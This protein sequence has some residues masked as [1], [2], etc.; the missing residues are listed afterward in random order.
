MS[1]AAV[2][3]EA[4]RSSP[5]LADHVEVWSLS[6]QSKRQGGER[7]LAVEPGTPDARAGQEVSDRF[8]AVICILFRHR[9]LSPH[10]Y[11]AG[12]ELRKRR[13]T[14]S[15]AALAAS[16]R[17]QQQKSQPA[18]Y[19]STLHRPRRRSCDLGNED[20]RSRI[21]LWC[22]RQVRSQELPSVVA[23]APARRMPNTPAV[24]PCGRGSA[25]YHCD[26]ATPRGRVRAQCRQTHG[27]APTATRSRRHCAADRLPAL[28]TGL[29]NESWD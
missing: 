27:F 1:E 13:F 11:T 5:E 2:V 16:R 4:N 25:S 22:Y 7:C 18:S 23:I 20:R 9:T 28:C 6:G 29:E 14:W 3:L 21:R 19:R 26:P 8:Q 12:N 17:Q 10:G 24:G 15:A